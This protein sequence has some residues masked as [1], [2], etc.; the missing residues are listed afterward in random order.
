MRR[1][2]GLSGLME[3]QSALAAA[4]VLQAP[5]GV[6]SRQRGIWGTLGSLRGF[7]RLTAHVYQDYHCQSPFIRLYL[8]GHTPP[9][10]PTK[11]ACKEQCIME[12]MG[13]VGLD[14]SFVAKA[15]SLRTS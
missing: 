1:K 5:P 12:S 2:I 10:P 4:L 6:G 14:A 3:S 8:L 7:G 9:T 11:A 15:L 13:H